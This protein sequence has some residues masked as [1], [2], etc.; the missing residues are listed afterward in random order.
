MKEGGSVGI[1]Q[2]PEGTPEQIE[3]AVAARPATAE[4]AR[5]RNR[6]EYT[7]FVAADKIY[8]GT[9]LGYN[10]GDVVGK[11]VVTRK[12][13]PIAREQVVEYGSKEHNEIR[14]RQGLPPV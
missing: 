7:H 5:E 3:A 11:D 6:E 14:D 10:P 12:G 2:I 1:K 4:Q 8:F 9:A 13:A